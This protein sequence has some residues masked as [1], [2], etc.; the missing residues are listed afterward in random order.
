MFCC[1]T[2]CC[3]V[4]FAICCCLG[5]FVLCCCTVAADVVLTPSD[6][7]CCI[8]LLFGKF[9]TFKIECCAVVLCS[10]CPDV[11]L[12]CCALVVALC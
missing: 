3:A 8:L 7:E 4:Y 10:F 2:A 6:A 5:Y 9:R 11:L 1:A 12:C